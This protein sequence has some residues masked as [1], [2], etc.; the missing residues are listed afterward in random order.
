MGARRGQRPGGLWPPPL[1]PPLPRA[2]PAEAGRSAGNS[3]STRPPRSGSSAMGV[4]PCR[5]PTPPRHS[6][7]AQ[8]MRRA[9]VTFCVCV[10]LQGHG[11]RNP[12]SLVGLSGW[13]CQIPH[14]PFRRAVP[15]SRSRSSSSSD[16]S[17]G[18]SSDGSS[19]SS[20]DGSSSSG[21]DDSSSSSSGSSDVAWPDQTSRDRLD[22]LKKEA[23]LLACFPTGLTGPRG[24][25]GLRRAGHGTG[26][27]PSLTPLH[28]V[29][30]RAS[31]ALAPC[32]EG[33]LPFLC[34]LSQ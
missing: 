22:Q 17:S 14:P 10:A 33:P 21:S 32:R 29:C 19:S 18:S 26:L 1:S 3:S 11:S 16:G 5:H 27:P 34:L 24:N 25:Q 7:V 30:R 15:G 9:R 6:P 31:I 23:C 8:R 4:P 12:A 20:S 13:R 28:G 2:C